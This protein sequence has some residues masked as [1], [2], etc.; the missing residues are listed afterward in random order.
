MFHEFGHALHGLFSNVKYPTARRHQR[1]RA[2]S[3]S[4]RRSSTSTGR[5]SRPCSR[6][7]RKHYQTGAPMPAELVAKIEKA[8]KFNQGFATTEY[9]AAALLDMAWH[10]LPDGRARQTGRR[11][12]RGGVACSASRSTSRSCRRATGRATSRTSGAAVTRRATT[13][14]CGARCSTHDA[15]EW[16]EEHGG[17]TRENG[18]RFRDMILSRGNTQE[19]ALPVSRVPRRATRA[20]SRSSSSAGSSRRRARTRVTSPEPSDMT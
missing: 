12:V 4:S 15:F 20:S 14:T 9:L 7:T 13:R 3:S 10:T 16:F 11:H 19:M 18:Q 8:R 5:T 6:T 2:T 1:R 17:M